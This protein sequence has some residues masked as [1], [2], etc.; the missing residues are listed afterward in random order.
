MAVQVF[1][2]SVLLPFIQSEWSTNNVFNNNKTAQKVSYIR[3]IDCLDCFYFL[4][5]KV[6]HSGI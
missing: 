1:L 3:Q 2:F 5:N 6:I 4:S